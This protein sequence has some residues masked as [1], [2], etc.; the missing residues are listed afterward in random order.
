MKRHGSVPSGGFTL[1]ELLVVISI[2]GLLV[3]IL[4][5]VI[6]A[7]RQQAETVRVQKRVAELANGCVSYY[8]AENYY[9]GQADPGRLGSPPNPPD[10]LTGSQC[11]AKALLAGNHADFEDKDLF[12]PP[13]AGNLIDSISD[14]RSTPMAILYYPSRLGK[15]GMEQY[16]EGDNSAYYTSGQIDRNFT[17]YIRD[18]RFGGTGPYG[19]NEFLII[20]AGKNEKYFTGDGPTYPKF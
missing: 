18:P 5:P 15:T 4:V 3:T 17:A 6:Q 1:I 7:A 19:D 10:L 16:V 13:G 2:I 14:K 9:P 11:L 12:D 20:A 8:H